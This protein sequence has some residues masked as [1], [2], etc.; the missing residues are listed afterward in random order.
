MNVGSQIVLQQSHNPILGFSAMLT[1]VLLFSVM[2]S[3][4]KWLGGVYPTHQIMFFRCAV[5]LVPVLYFVWRAGG[6][7]RLRTRRPGM[8]VLRSVV[9][10][11][12]MGCAFYGFSTLP[13]AVASSVFYT[14]PLFATA[15]SVPILGEHVGRQRWCCIL[16]GLVGTLIVIRPGS[17]VFSLSSVIML[18]ASLLVA[19]STNIIRKLSAD[20]DAVCITFYFT[21]SGTLVTSVIGLWWGWRLPTGWDL[22]LLMSVGLLGG[23]AQYALTR[24]FRYAEV[25]LLAPLKYFSIVIGGVIGY[26]VWSETPDLMTILG[27]GIIIAS[28]FYAMVRETAVHGQRVRTGVKR[29]M[30][31]TV[32]R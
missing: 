24:S 21:L 1:S 27:I 25:G 8:H 6:I 14:A 7:E 11:S 32:D 31:V 10:M 2:D 26:V 18:M 22:V 20:D 19:L 23:C 5:A 12:A 17:A 28:G 29:A 30:T 16:V 9:G 3:V 4:V 13:L 15:F